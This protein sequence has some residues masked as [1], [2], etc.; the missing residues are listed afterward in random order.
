MPKYLKKKKL[1]FFRKKKY[2]M[3]YAYTQTV[4]S[5]CN[6]AASALID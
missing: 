3:S 6:I 4:A 1:N 5:V 2:Q